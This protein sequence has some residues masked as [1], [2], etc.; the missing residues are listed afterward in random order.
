MKLTETGS[1]ITVEDETHCMDESY[2]VNY[3]FD[4]LFHETMAYHPTEQLQHRG[5]SNAMIVLRRW[6]SW[7]PA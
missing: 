2:G 5:C 3:L 4:V 1:I 7:S 6:K